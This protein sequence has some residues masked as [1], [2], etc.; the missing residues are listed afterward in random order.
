MN[1]QMSTH[2]TRRHAN[3]REVAEML[4]LT[5]GDPRRRAAF[6]SVQDDGDFKH[7]WQ[8]LREQKGEENLIPKYRKSTG[9]RKASDYLACPHCKAIYKRTLLSKHERRCKQKPSAAVLKKGQ[10]AAMGKLLLPIPFG[11][12]SIILF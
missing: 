4:T 9:N 10:C 5:K 12:T 7:N 11:M 8:V 3:E 2:L 6:I 1:T